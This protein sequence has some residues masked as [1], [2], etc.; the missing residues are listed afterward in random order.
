MFTCCVPVFR[1]SR[2]RKAQSVRLLCCCG[3]R[4][5]PHGQFGRRYPKN[6]TQE[7]FE[8]LHDGFDFSPSLVK[9][10]EQQAA[11]SILCWS[12]NSTQEMFE[13]LCVGFD[14]SP[15][16]VKG[17]EQQATSSILCRSE[18][19]TLSVAEACTMLTLKAGAVQKVVGCLQPSFHGRSISV[20]TF[21]CV[22]QAFYPTPQVLDQLLQ[23]ALSPIWGPRPQEN[24]QDMWQMLRHSRINLTLAYLQDLLPGSV[25][26]HQATPLLIQ[27][28]LFQ[29]TELETEA[30][31]PAPAL[32][33]GAEA[34]KGPHLEL[35]GTPVLFLPSL[36][37]LEPAA[38]PSA[39]PD[40]E[41]VPSAAPAQV[42]GPEL[43]STGPRGLL[44]F[45]PQ[46][47]V[48]AAESA[49]VPEASHPCRV[50]GKKQPDG[51]PSLMAFSPRDVAEQLTAIDAEVFKNVEPS[52]CL[53][54]TWGKRNRPGHENVA[55]TVWA[56]VVQF[57]RVVKCVMTSC[58]GDPNVTAR[59]RAKVLERW[60]EVA[61]ECRALRNISSLH[62][63]LSALQSVPIHRLKKTWGK[64]S[65]KSYRKF[66]KL[67]D[68]DNSLSWELLIKSS[69]DEQEDGKQPSKFA[70]L[71]RTLQRGRKRQ[72]Q[73]GIVPF[74][75]TMLTDLIMLDTAMEDYVNGNEINHEK[76]KKEHK[77]MME[78]VQLQEAAENYNLEPQERFR[79]WFWDM[80]QLS[81]DESYSLSC[82]LEPRC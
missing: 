4:I 20:T 33:P 32:L 22:Y 55:P 16:L 52:E 75:G 59:G 67:C 7:I 46:A 72:Q 38:A 69:L 80:E 70:T 27:V 49:P 56:T 57:N 12:E 15:S 13:E 53:G 28:D 44:G 60:I 54:S 5:K 18:E 58:L 73:K 66:K 63:V 78:I 21:P 36:L 8:E 43:D 42:P 71:L 65:R 19:P 40:P 51:K 62:A 68:E 6:S 74:L 2:L 14:F 34:E 48:T 37:A 30:P 81:E 10:Q 47:P 31:A 45:P 3:H 82:Q 64:V 41:R 25:L 39:A 23:S 79:A 9:G 61:R 29:A 35:D 76:K 50:T 77:V 17:Q 11:S 1:G 24:S 26:K